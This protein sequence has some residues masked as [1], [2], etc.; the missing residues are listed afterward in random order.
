[1]PRA[2]M[3]TPTHWLMTDLET[4]C[5][6]QTGSFSSDPAEVTCMACRFRG[7]PDPAR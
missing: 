4:V 3:A 5:G 6:S 2:V 1:M 7:Q